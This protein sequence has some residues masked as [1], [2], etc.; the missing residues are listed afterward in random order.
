MSQSLAGKLLV[1]HPNLTGPFFQKSLVYIVE[2]DA[3][4]GAQGIVLNKPINYSVQEIF[5]QNGFITDT[6]QSLHKGG[7]VNQHSVSILHTGE[8]MSQNTYPTG[9]YCVSSDKFMIEKM[10]SGPAPV[11]WRMFTGLAGWGP[12]QLEMEI[13]GEGPFTERSWL[14]LEPN[15]TIVFG[16][17]GEKQWNKAIKACSQQMVDVYF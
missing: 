16:A 1:A 4:Q 17:D 13:N 6:R 12:G 7:P 8:W 3:H 15:D 9:N 14:T 11:Y 5:A 10:A 2:H